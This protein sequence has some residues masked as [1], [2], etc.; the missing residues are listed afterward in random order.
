VAGCLVALNYW[1]RRNGGSGDERCDRV[2]A[3]REKRA[4]ETKAVADRVAGVKLGHGRLRAADPGCATP[5]VMEHHRHTRR[6]SGCIKRKL[7][8]VNRASGWVK[9]LAT[10]RSWGG[11]AVRI[12]DLSSALETGIASA[13]CVGAAR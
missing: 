8:Y 11:P 6:R 7:P 2:G 10:L 12:I 5:A 9:S 4:V 1:F 3:V 13:R